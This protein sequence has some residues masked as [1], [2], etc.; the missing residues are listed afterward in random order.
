MV[1]RERG[2]S[3]ESLDEEGDAGWYVGGSSSGFSRSWIDIGREECEVAFN[4]LRYSEYGED[5][6]FPV[7]TIFYCCI[8]KPDK[9]S[10]L[11]KY[12]DVKAEDRR[13]CAALYLGD[14]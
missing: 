8:I 6:F 1:G 12:V 13:R 14:D 9:R 11:S 5:I 7:R 2:L 4:S 3:T 10:N